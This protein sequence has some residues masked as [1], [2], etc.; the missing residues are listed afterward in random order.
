MSATGWSL[1]ADGGMGR[2]HFAET[3]GTDARPTGTKH[4]QQAPCTAEFATAQKRHLRGDGNAED[5]SLVMDRKKQVYI[6]DGKL[7]K[8]N[9]T[10]TRPLERSMGQKIRVTSARN[11]IPYMSGGDKPY[12]SPEYRCVPLVFALLPACPH[13]P[14]AL[15]TAVRDSTWTIQFPVARRGPR[16]LL[17]K[18]EGIR[19]SIRGWTTCSHRSA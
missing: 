5:A 3:R 1:P 7:L 18:H 6:E 17:G 12:P 14:M 15:G 4:I 11:G 8:Y 2:V 19:R 13:R 9:Q 10:H 16:Q